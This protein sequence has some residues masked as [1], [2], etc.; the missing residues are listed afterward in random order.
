[1]EHEI[2]HSGQV[3]W[4]TGLSG[5]G[6]STI[7]RAVEMRVREMGKF[8]TVIDGDSFRQT[9]SKDLGFS[10]GDRSE[11]NRR[12]AEVAR[13]FAGQ[14]ALTLAAFVSP[15]T[16]DRERARQIIGP[17]NFVEIFVDCPVEECERRD[18]KGLYARARR[19][20]IGQFTGLTSRFEAPVH[21]DLHLETHKLTVAQAVEKIL[22]LLDKS[23]D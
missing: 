21:P 10:D 2:S 17:E 5:S 7:A 3:V 18:P 4:F 14:G 23:P 9:V 16:A 6:K 12:A 19:G 20:E 11:N 8:V 22:T 15:F 13:L 1:V